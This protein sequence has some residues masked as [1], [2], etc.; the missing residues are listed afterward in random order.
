[1]RFACWITKATD[2]HS[3]YIILSS[4]PLQQW[5][6][7]RALMLRYTWAYIACRVICPIRWLR[8]KAETCC[9]LEYKHCPNTVVIYDII[10]HLSREDTPLCFIK[11]QPPLT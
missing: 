3:E 4:F 5:L 8:I 1:M 11:F 2:A 7:Q 6:R 10:V 9:S